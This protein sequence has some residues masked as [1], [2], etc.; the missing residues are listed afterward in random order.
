MMTNQRQQLERK[1]ERLKARLSKVG[2]WI[3]GSVSVTERICGKKNCAC[4]QGG[5]KHPAMFVTWKEARK[6]VALYVPRKMEREVRA[7]AE[8]YRRVKEILAEAS[9]VQKQILRLRED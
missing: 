2:P 8:N 6:T 3:Q 4:R 1:Q 5:P 9:D 7:W